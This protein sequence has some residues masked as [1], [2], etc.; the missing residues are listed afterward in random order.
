VKKLLPAPAKIIDA[1]RAQFFALRLRRN[2]SKLLTLRWFLPA[3]NCSRRSDVRY[4]GA[5]QNPHHRHGGS[6]MTFTL[7]VFF[8]FVNRQRQ[9]FQKKIS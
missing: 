8:L 4:S 1:R 3:G 9:N 5:K 2:P 6:G 7:K